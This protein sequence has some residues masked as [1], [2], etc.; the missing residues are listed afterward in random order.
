MQFLMAQ[1]TEEKKPIDKPVRA[2]FE[3][4]VIIDNQTGII[5]TANTLEFIIEHHFGTVNNGITDIYG[6]YAPSN[7]RLGLNY[8]LRDNLMIGFGST[9]NKKIQDF[10]VKYN[11]LEQT[12]KNTIP[13]ALSLYGNFAIN[14][15]NEEEFGVNYKFTNRLSYFGQIIVARKINDAIS[16]QFAPSFSHINSVNKELEHDKVA[17]SFS[18]RYRFSAQSSVI[19]NYDIPLH[20]KSLQENTELKFKSKPNLAIG[21]EVSTSTHAFQVFIGTADA[22][23]SQY[24][25]MTNGNDWT[26][27]EMMIGFNIT[28]LWN[29]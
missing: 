15:M 24:N 3:S 17:I 10:R 29:F 21:F 19:F 12:R 23:V 9:K 5:Q 6:I 4:G 2:P 1:D 8:S 27:G 18:G 22:L 14:A 26:K 16:I 13:I 28:R 7:I 20:I 11:I 25:I